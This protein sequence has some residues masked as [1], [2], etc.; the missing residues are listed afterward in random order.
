[1]KERRE[2]V[3]IV[4]GQSVSPQLLAQTQ[5]LGMLLVEADFRIATGG[6]GGV[7]EAALR[8]GREA[9]SWLEGRTMAILPSLKAEDANP[10]ADIVIPTGMNYARNTI[11]VAMADIVIAVG[12][13]A[14]TLSEIALAWQHNKPIIAM[15][16]EE[17]WSSRLAG[18]SLDQ[19]R[20]DVVHAAKTPKEAVEKAVQLSKSRE[21]SHGFV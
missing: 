8:G 5:E 6:R 13:G 2:I 14:G 16:V 17:G 15:D 7:M 18:L 12:G 4:G 19:R 10:Y 21:S 20:D 11:L 9:N 1:M 3:A